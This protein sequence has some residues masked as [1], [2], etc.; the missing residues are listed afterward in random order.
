MKIV[1]TSDLHGY[2][3]KI[4]PCELL[5]ICGDIVP[6]R[7]QNNVPQCSKWF[8][9]E[10]KNWIE[11]IPCDK[12]IMTPGN[13]DYALAQMNHEIQRNEFEK[14]FFCSVQNR[15][16][17][18]SYKLTCLWNQYTSYNG[19]RIFGTPYCKIFGNWSFMR[20]PSELNAKFADIPPFLDIL[21]THDPAFNLGNT[22]IAQ[23]E[24]HGNIELRDRLETLYNK[25]DGLPK[26]YFCGHFHEGEH[27]LDVWNGMKFANTS[28]VDE[29]YEPAFEPL[30]LDI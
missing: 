11:E 28:L 12:V 25:Y 7:M 8:N 2:L 29:A 9:R 5:L 1:V 30:V 27:K 10:F 20:V 13:H 15:K 16:E 24:H 17:I 3:P 6:L 4:A 18:F 23:G 21:L 26:Y 19:L 14:I 22:D